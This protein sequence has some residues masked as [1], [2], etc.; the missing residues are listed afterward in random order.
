MR[1]DEIELP[2]M[3]GLD[4]LRYEVV[5]AAC[6]AI[7][8]RSRWIA[9]LSNLVLGATAGFAALIVTNVDKVHAY[10]HSNCPKLTFAFMAISACLGVL[11]QFFTSWAQM[12]VGIEKQTRMALEK[13]FRDPDKYGVDLTTVDLRGEVALPALTDFV[14]SRPWPFRSMARR[15][16]KRSVMDHAYLFK[17]AAT[18]VQL[19]LLCL[20]FQYAFFALAVFFPLWKIFR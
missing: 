12:A 13:A 4:L 20:I 19:M 14:S 5:R 6:S 10:L 16:L 11:I 9:T 3:N 15:G 1:H 17:N 2:A 18:K 8:R 7:I